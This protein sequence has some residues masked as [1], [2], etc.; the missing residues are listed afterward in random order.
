M[1]RNCLLGVG[2]KVRARFARLWPDPS[3][4]QPMVYGGVHLPFRLI[5]WSFLHLYEEALGNYFNYR[6]VKPCKSMDI[7]Q[8]SHMGWVHTKLYPWTPNLHL[9]LFL[10]RTKC[11]LQSAYY[12]IC[13]YIC[14]MYGSRRFYESGYSFEGHIAQFD[15]KA[16]VKGSNWIT[17]SST[18]VRMGA[19]ISNYIHSC[20]L[21]NSP[22]TKCLSSGLGHVCSIHV[23]W[24]LYEFGYSLESI[25]WIYTKVQVKGSNFNNSS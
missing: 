13:T 5:R 17:P 4:P 14:S 25:A 7:P 10:S 6:S 18:T 20:F 11:F 1:F 2:G 9:Y 12:R 21:L 8:K 15:T 24:R 3:S 19:K 23:G 22:L 16:Q